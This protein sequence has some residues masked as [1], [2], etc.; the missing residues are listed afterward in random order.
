M[1]W[2]TSHFPI[3]RELVSLPR[4]IPPLR[5]RSHRNLLIDKPRPSFLR[6]YSRPF[7]FPL[8]WTSLVSYALPGPIAS[9]LLVPY[10]STPNCDPSIPN[11]SVV[12]RLTQNNPQFH[13]S[14][15]TLTPT[16]DYRCRRVNR[17]ADLAWLGMRLLGTASLTLTD[18]AT[19]L[20][21]VS[22]GAFLGVD[23]EWRALNAA[24]WE[25][26]L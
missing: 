26:T 2:G 3:I 12:P 6:T 14:S 7:V 20:M 9:C 13:T 17:G 8:K 4:G 18:S 10:W 19:R 24:V 1:R 22:N 25:L 15:T 5:C 23:G 16:F 21:R 11:G